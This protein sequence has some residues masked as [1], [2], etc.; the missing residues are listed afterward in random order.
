MLIRAKFLVDAQG[1]NK[2]QG[3]PF[4]VGE[5]L[6]KIESLTSVGKAG[7]LSRAAG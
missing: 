7:S 3:K 4:G 1:Y 2:V 5:L 6:E